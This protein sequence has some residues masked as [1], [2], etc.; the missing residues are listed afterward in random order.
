LKILI[1][2]DHPLIREGLVNVLRELDPDVHVVEAEDGREALSLLQH[3]PDVTLLLLDL[4][5]PDI[6]GETLLDRVR[7]A[8]PDVPVVV[9]SATDDSATVRHAID[10]GAMGFISKRSASAVLV[11]ALKLVLVGGVYIPPQALTGASQRASPA[12]GHESPAASTLASRGLTAR[13]TDVLTL[14][15]QGKST[16]IICRELGISEGTAKAHTA[17][18]FRALNVANRTQAVFAVSRLGYQLPLL[19]RSGPSHAA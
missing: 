13:Q 10:A 11:N 2:D 9:L 19:A 5:L 18:I 8:R 4:V 15:V 12:A 1:V 16:K 6:E 7:G 17:A 3:N 14:L